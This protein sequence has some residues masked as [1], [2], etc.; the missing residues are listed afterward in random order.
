MVAVAMQIAASSA[1]HGKTKLAEAV[2][3]L[4]DEARL[5]RD[6]VARISPSGRGAFFHH[7]RWALRDRVNVLRRE[8]ALTDGPCAKWEA[9]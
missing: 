4:L 3:A 6:H 9:D 8:S 2:R 1:K 7:A 5:R